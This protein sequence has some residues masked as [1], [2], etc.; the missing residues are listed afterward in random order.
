MKKTQL[1]AGG[2]LLAA[3][4]GVQAYTGFETA[5][6]ATSSNSSYRMARTMNGNRAASFSNTRF[7]GKNR[8]GASKASST[9]P[10]I[11]GMMQYSDSWWNLPEGS[12]YPYGCYEISKSRPTPFEMYAHPN[13]QANGGG[14]YTDRQVHYRIWELLTDEPWFNNYYMVVNTDEWYYVQDPLMS[15]EQESIASD[16]TYDPISKKIYAAVWSNFDGGN[17]KLATVNPTT[18]AT[19]EIATIPDMA[20]LVAN[21][22]GELYGVELITG[23]TYRFN[24]E[25]G[26]YVAIGNSGLSPKY[27]Q[28][29]CVDPETNVIY[30]LATL[31]DDTANIYTLN[32][33]TGKADLYINL[34][35]NSEYTCAF[36]EAPTKGL[37]APAALT[38]FSAIA[39]DGGSKISFT[40]PSKAFD[41][42]A[43]GE[44]TVKVYADGKEIYSKAVAAGGSDEFVAQ[45]GDGK[46]SIVAFAV[47]S[48][49][50]GEKTIVE[51]Y[52]GND[53]PA[54]PSALN[55]T[56]ADNVATLT[57]EAP[58]AGLHGGTIEADKVRYNVVRYPGAELVAE[59]LNATSFTET[60]P[61]GMANYY[62]MVTSI[63]GEQIGGTATSNSWFA[64]AA[65]DV[66]YIQSFDTAAG[67]DGF[68]IIDGDG[69]GNCWDYSDYWKAAW[70]KY[71]LH[72][73]SDN[74]LITPPI[75]FAA[76]SSY[77]LSFRAKAFDEDSPERFEVMFGKT[78]TAEG[79]TTSLVTPV[80]TNNENFTT[81]TA[82]FTTDADGV[83]YIGFHAISPANSYRLIIDDIE[84]RLTA[85]AGVPAAVADLK[86]TPASDGSAKVTLSFTA[87]D[88][89]QDGTK[90]DA[91]TAIEIF[92]DAEAV[93]AKKFEN[94]AP[95]QKL[96]WTDENAPAGDVTYRVV[97]SNKS[98]RGIEATTAVFVGFD[99]PLPASNLKLIINDDKELILTWK[100]PT[101]TVN[102]IAINPEHLSYTITRNDGTIMVEKTKNTS[103]T[104][105]TQTLVSAQKMVY[106]QVE[107][108]YGNQQGEITIG[109][110]VIVG[111]PLAVPFK[112]SFS[113]QSLENAPWVISRLSGHT[114]MRWSL[115]KQASNPTA[116]SQDNDGG[117]ASFVAFDQNSGLMERMTSPK[118]DLFSADHPVLK[119][120][121]YG[122]T[123]TTN[124]TLAVQ[125]SN[126]DQD[127]HTLKELTAKETTEG[128]KEITVEI[129][130][131][132]CTESAMISFLGTT[133]RG[134][135]IHIDNIRIENGDSD[136]SDYDLE[137][138]KLD[139]PDLMPDQ[140]AKINFTV[141]N[142]GERAIDNYTVS[143]IVNGMEMIKANS[144]TSIAPGETYIYTFKIEPEQSDLNQT[145][146]FKGRITCAADTNADNNETEE[147]A[148]TVGVSG[149][150][151]VGIADETIISVFTLD[152]I[153]IMDSV[154]ASELGKLSKGIYLVKSG[155]KTVKV[156]I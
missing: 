36:I 70:S 91:L 66:P 82:N 84:V 78:P 34:A 10:K 153:R 32:T 126:N 128:W 45:L 100:A 96:E 55:L 115:Q 104:D 40:A 148:K 99:K 24:K 112:E 25:T 37:N 26:E 90:I 144:D 110:Y 154:N 75:K 7:D 80:I 109:D 127:F 49:G 74:W 30:W 62:Y 85:S 20:C 15:H 147:V 59:N 103:F 145:F 23:T 68:T 118:I 86:A 22:F 142:N 111:D 102:G 69:D 18:G 94:P 149:L 44:L 71:N 129:P 123:G 63:V 43:P 105:V 119:F 65:F 42:S 31:A 16:M 138:V 5:P 64:G 95:G 98:G 1:L 140:E 108:F 150:S 6:K 46:H 14:C 139:V 60:L 53:L 58:T 83:A 124:E 48:V 81:Y 35:D 130:R 137:A 4:I 57:W 12:S 11:Y 143:L 52:T 77:K 50:E 156:K 51:H 135:N 87:P 132:Y 28:S 79:M 122:H 56:V 92:R 73:Q 106:Y 125:I 8:K 155:K 134:F 67:M 101:Q 38:D 29:A 41:G 152:G 9:G 89:T 2:C 117:F 13:L 39:A 141:Y 33:S 114:D 54:A 121:I 61:E 76:N 107:T 116:T 133:A 136:L 93:P 72:E 120:Y 19:T 17:N 47:N 3:A 113:E 131:K 21:N 151:E 146:R 88:K 27:M 97:A